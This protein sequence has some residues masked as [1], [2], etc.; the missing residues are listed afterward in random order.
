MLKTTKLD[1]PMSAI[2]FKERLP[3][4]SQF[5][6][7]DIVTKVK[8][9]IDEQKQWLLNQFEGLT[10]FTKVSWEGFIIPW[11]DKQDELDRYWSLVSH[12][13]AVHNSQAIREPYAEAQG[14]LSEWS[15]ELGQNTMLFEVYQALAEQ[16][17][18]Q[19]QRRAVELSLRSFRLSGIDLPE[20]DKDQ[21]A[22][23]KSELSQLTTQYANNVLDCTQAWSY[24]TED[25]LDLAGLPETHLK[26][27]AQR[28]ADSNDPDHTEKGFLLT[29]DIPVY[30]AVM[31]HSQNRELR[32]I[33]YDAYASRAS[34]AGPHSR[35][36]DNTENLGKILSLRHSMA[37]LLGFSNYAELS[38]ARKM[39]DSPQQVEDFLL[40]LLH[41]SKDRASADVQELKRFAKDE[42]GIELEAWDF[43]YV[44]ERLKQQRYSLS[45]QALRAYFPHRTVLSGLFS[46]LSTLYDITIAAD[47]QVETSCDEAQFYVIEREGKA[48]AGLFLD[49]FARDGK[50]GGA[51]MSE[52]L[53]RQQDGG[54]ALQLPVA[55][56]CC[57]FAAP[58]DGEDAYLSHNEVT[59]L[60]HEFGHALHHTLTQNTVP[61]VSGINGVAWDAVELPSQF[62]ENFCYE[63]EVLALIS[64]HKDSGEPLS[65]DMLDKLLAAKNFLSGY[66]MLRQIEF[67]LFD[68]RIHSAA[69]ALSSDQ[70][71]DVLSDVRKHTNLLAVP[72]SN[73][74]QNA[75]THVFAGGYAAGYYSYKWAE[76]LSAD[77]YASFEEEGVLSAEPAQRFLKTLLSRGGAEDAMTLFKDFKGREPNVDALVRH[78][79][80]T[81]QAA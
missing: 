10:N 35:D 66:Q 40:D 45:E 32:K 56:I 50:R 17:L 75:F 14:L 30:L 36:Y 33:F 42:F 38:L 12:M 39:A 23:I 21:F 6:A 28:A 71:S 2:Y 55:Y 43:S 81:N 20:K 67:A 63:P 70:V 51:W 65:Q 80:I 69:D 11:Q 27:A 9:F 77:V 58:V 47:K 3:E 8:G 7:D 34:T 74:F 72:N 59:T 48:I 52:C 31:T 1:T 41:K 15:T 5:S 25:A 78:S 29:L 18:N 62:M 60:F 79:G 22:K 61:D 49:L 13:N 19:E 24:Y 68:L 37:A 64:K 46:L 73:Q 76:V 4:Y 54:G 16:K 53:N 57:N 26:M 44:A